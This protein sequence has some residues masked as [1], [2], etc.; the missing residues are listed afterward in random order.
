MSSE[1]PPRRSLSGMRSAPSSVLGHLRQQALLLH[2]EHLLHGA[3][4]TLIVLRPVGHPDPLDVGE[5]RLGN[6][7][8]VVL[9]PRGAEDLRGDRGVGHLRRAFGHGVS[10]PPHPHDVV[11]VALAE[12]VPDAGRRR[13]HVR[14]VAAVADD[15]V[16]ALLDAQVLAPEVP[17]DVHQLDRVERAAA[18]PRV[19]GAVRRFAFEGVL[20]RDHPVAPAV[21]PGGRHSAADVAVEDDVD[22]VEHPGPD[23][24]R[25][26]AELLL[27]DAGPDHER[28]VDL[29]P[30]HDLLHRERRGDV[31]RLAGVVTLA[32]PR[33]PVDQRLAVRR[34]G[35]LRRLRDAVDVAAERDHRPS[36]TPPGEPAA[37]HAR[38]P[39][40]D[41]E[42]LPLEDPGEV[43]LGLELLEAELAEAEL[44]VDH[45]LD[46]DAPVVDVLEHLFP[47]L[48]QPVLAT[49]L[50]FGAGTRFGRPRTDRS[51]GDDD[52]DGNDAGDDR[53]REHGAHVDPPGRPQLRGAR[54]GLIAADRETPLPR[55]GVIS[56]NDRPRRS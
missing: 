42:T 29:L 5:H 14:L 49:G 39:E 25:L 41:L 17:A 47:E 19:A 26:A 32:V 23:E 11:V 2:V 55:L 31:H 45:P 12:E 9:R 28:A 10:D 35:R 8:V 7:P 37:R 21:A 46:E 52:G 54:S 50:R 15:V 30:L 53:S 51:Q 48:L 3:G 6:H 20:D 18:V 38:R 24:V 44:G 34:A 40:L 1:P 4:E 33:R 43:T 13:H 16:R 22:V 56:R 27:G 36:G